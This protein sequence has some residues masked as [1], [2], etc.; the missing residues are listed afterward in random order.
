M[1]SKS[2]LV[3]PGFKSRTLITK[4]GYCFLTI[5]KENLKAHCKNVHKKPM[6]SAGERPISGVFKSAEADRRKFEDPEPEEPLPKKV[7]LVEPSIL[8]EKVLS[9]L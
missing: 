5:K 2:G 8:E 3:K 4:C 9:H 7:K 6:L 1:A